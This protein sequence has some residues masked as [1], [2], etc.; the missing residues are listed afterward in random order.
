MPHITN[1]C[2]EFLTLPHVTDAC[3]EFLMLSHITDACQEF[4]TL[5]PLLSVLNNLQRLMSHG[6]NYFKLFFI[7][8]VKVP[9]ICFLQKPQFSLF[10]LLAQ[11]EI[12][13]AACIYI[14]LYYWNNTEK[15]C[16]DYKNASCFVLSDC[17]WTKRSNDHS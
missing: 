12:R 4:L 11:L 8:S 16:C 15:H 5:S 13:S 6:K 10:C 7:P 1:A 14:Y 17:I 3:Q 2:Q 9:D